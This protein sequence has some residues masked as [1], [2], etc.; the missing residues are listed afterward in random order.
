MSHS[1]HPHST[2]GTVI[3][4][5]SHLHSCSQHNHASSSAYRLTPSR[6]RHA[7][8]R[9]STPTA[10]RLTPSRLDTRATDPPLQRTCTVHASPLFAPFC[11][12]GEPRVNKLQ[13]STSD[14]IGR[15]CV[16]CASIA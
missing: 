12:L 6:L 1:A 13:R 3:R 2:L 5:N 10:Y 9:P 11:A 8:Y 7:R 16:P 4:M 14:P 15:I